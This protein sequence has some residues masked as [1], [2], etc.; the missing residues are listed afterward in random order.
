ML[1]RLLDGVNEAPGPEV[2]IS[3]VNP[4][5]G[6]FF[7]LLVQLEKSGPSVLEAGHVW[8][9]GTVFEW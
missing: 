1:Q 3:T 5:L 2:T 9:G 6:F 8:F 7:W 4:Y